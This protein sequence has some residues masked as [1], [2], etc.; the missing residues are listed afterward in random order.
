[1]D[2][3][4]ALTSI[5]KDEQWSNKLLAGGGIIFCMIFTVILPLIIFLL[6]D[7]IICGMIA[8]V[9]SL[10]AFFLLTFLFL[11]Y[12]CK[13]ANEKITNA[14]AKLPNW[15]GFGKLI[16]IGF[17][18]IVGILIYTLPLNIVGLAFLSIL[19][20][21]LSS[22]SHDFLHPAWFFF[23]VFL[24][25]IVL[26][27]Y[28]LTMLFMP[29]MQCNFLKSFKI[30]SFID[31]KS[32]FNML[33]NN[34]NNYFILILLLIALSVLYQIVFGILSFTIVGLIF[35]PMFILYLYLVIAELYVQF[36]VAVKTED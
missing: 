21:S 8:A 24:G 33:K 29:L 11:G 20:F 19:I 27:L 31:F 1:M 36:I 16:V 5:A 22:R 34:I 18:Y 26:S 35:V 17:K 4:S 25:A 15:I 13:Y 2:F 23:M 6:S 14:D 3:E 7:S 10:L 28:I 30:V 32:A 9:L 12:V